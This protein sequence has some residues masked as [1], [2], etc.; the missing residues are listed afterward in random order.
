MTD[1]KNYYEI[2]HVQQDAPAEV[3]QATYR[4]MM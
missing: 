4:T 1:Q 2:L 3:I